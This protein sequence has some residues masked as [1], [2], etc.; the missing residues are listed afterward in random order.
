M[1]A[2]LPYLPIYG[3]RRVRASPTIDRYARID[4]LLRQ[5]AA[6]F[7]RRVEPTWSRLVGE[8]R[9]LAAE[10]RARAAWARLPHPELDEE[11]L[12]RPVFV[13][14]YPKSGTT[15]LLGLL[16]GHP[17]L[18]VIPGETRWFTDPTPTLDQLHER[19]IHLLINPTGQ[20][21]FWLLG[22]PTDGA[23]PYLRFT[24]ALL[25]IAARNP[26][27]DL[28]TVLA[29]VFA[30]EAPCP[31]AWVEKTPLHVFHFDRIRRQ[32]P[33]ARFIQVVRDP[34]T[35]VAAIRRFREHGWTTDLDETTSG[36]AAALECAADI[37]SDNYLVVRYEDLVTATERE[38]RRVATFV[39]VEWSPT[40]LCPTQMGEPRRANSSHL[41][42]RVV[43]TIH[44]RSLNAG[45]AEFDE[46]TLALINARTSASARALGYD[47]PAVGRVR[48][49]A[50]EV[51]ERIRRAEARS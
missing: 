8:L 20:E 6:D 12:A 36:V 42:R 27:V 18:A 39:G 48:A 46:H 34:R 47:M 45:E 32:F 21:P 40:L 38:L 51:A 1:R 16:D 15:L 25:G 44:E 24:E 35:T 9:E 13:V 31:R 17:Q 33:D 5:R 26:E 2:F 28:L 49:L 22:Q 29:A 4:E 50:I 3:P 11:L 30:E 43:G 19:W 41:D 7:P 23:D 37:S 14:G 10:L